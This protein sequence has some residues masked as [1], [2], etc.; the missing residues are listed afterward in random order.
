M[1][2]MHLINL[3]SLCK[4]TPKT[5]LETRIQLLTHRLLLGKRASL[6]A[7]IQQHPSHGPG[8]RLSIK[9]SICKSPQPESQR[10]QECNNHLPHALVHF[11]S[12][13]S[14]QQVGGMKC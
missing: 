5:A 9:L 2:P 12:M 1:E 6:T 4:D 7:V 10:A 3:Q 14:W 11:D 8:Q 13:G